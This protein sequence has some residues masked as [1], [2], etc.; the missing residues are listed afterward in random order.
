MKCRKHSGPRLI[1]G[2]TGNFG[3]GKTTVAGYFKSFGAKIIDADKI[4]HIVIEPG[5]KAY[6][7]IIGIFGKEIVKKN[8]TI[9]RVLLSKIVFNNSGLLKR[10]NRIIHPEVGKIIKEE[11][12]ASREKVI[13]L[14]VPLLYESGLQYLADK[15]IVVKAR[16]EKQ[17]ERIVSGRSFTKEEIIKR[18]RAQMRLSDKIRRADF[19]IDN[20]GSKENTKKQVEKLRRIL[21]KN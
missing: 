1:L 6:N 4:A 9:D 13:V 19:V 21:W 11:I 14:D 17:F 3:T 12:K 16:R 2:I 5:S 20:S 10:L 7:K 8:K 18:I 15:I